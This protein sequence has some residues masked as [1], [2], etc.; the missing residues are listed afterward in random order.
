[1]HGFSE[2]PGVFATHN[3]YQTEWPNYCT[4]IE[5]KHVITDLVG[6]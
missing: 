1:M 3:R 4:K 6:G 5:I 2:K